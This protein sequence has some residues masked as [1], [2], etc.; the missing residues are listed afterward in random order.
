MI[1]IIYDYKMTKRD[2]LLLKALNN[3]A[4][5]RFSEFETLIV[6]CGWIFRRQAGGHRI[7][8]SPGR[9]RLPTQP[10]ENGRAKRYQV[11]QFLT[12]YEVENG[13]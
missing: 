6:Q 9:Y 3:P 8:F 5:L 13:K 2:K 10:D 12:Q 4:G 1:V 7:Y 11:E